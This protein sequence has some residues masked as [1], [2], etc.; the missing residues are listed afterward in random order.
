MDSNKNVYYNVLVSFYGNENGEVSEYR[1][2]VRVDSFS[3]WLGSVDF[4]C[5]EVLIRDVE[6]IRFDLSI[7][8]PRWFKFDD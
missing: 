2:F 3:D 1:W 8:A 4:H 5:R 6:I 7:P